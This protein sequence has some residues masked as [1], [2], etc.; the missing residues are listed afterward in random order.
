MIERLLLVTGAAGATLVL[1]RERDTGH[2]LRE[3]AARMWSVEATWEQMQSALPVRSGAPS[4][5]LP[6][7]PA[8]TL[9]G[10]PMVDFPLFRAA[11][12]AQ[13]DDEQFAY[14]DERYVRAGRTYL[15]ASPTTDEGA[16]EVLD[17]LW[18][19]CADH[20]EALVVTRAAQAAALTLGWLLKVDVLR[21]AEH[22]NA[23]R[24]RIL[25]DAELARLRVYAD[26]RDSAP[27]VLFNSGL[28]FE[29]VARLR[30]ADLSPDGELVGNA[31]RD[32]PLSE[33]ARLQL[34]AL[35]CH[36]QL[37]ASTPQDPI[38]SDS[39]RT[40]RTAVHRAA[41]DTGLPLD[42]NQHGPAVRRADRWQHR[43]GMSLQNL[44]ES[45]NERRSRR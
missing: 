34:R 4:R 37:I 41:V 21:L 40:I 35:R 10:L 3:V 18:R 39:C 25:T 31:H 1:V 28:P 32:A 44:I 26:P 5:A 11:C 43:L 7:G 8:M 33:E 36:A 29:E 30:V 20:R 12:R 6:G 24:H 27:A 19:D 45:P 22:V 2:E 23:A 9:P 14:C 15:A 38:V 42:V 16:R 13:L 17:D